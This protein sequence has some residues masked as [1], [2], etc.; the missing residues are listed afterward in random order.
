MNEHNE[1]ERLISM[2]N[3]MIIVYLIIALAAFGALTGYFLISRGRA[4]NAQSENYCGVAAMQSAR[5]VANFCEN[6]EM[7]SCIAFED[8]QLSAF[9][10]KGSEY[11]RDEITLRNR[12]TELLTTASYMSDYCDF[13]I[14]YSNNTTAGIVS[15][16][17]LDHF[18]TAAYERSVELLDG[19]DDSWNVFYSDNVSRIC[20]LKRVNSNAV[21]IS[22]VYST[23]FGHVF[24][25]L[26]DTSS[27]SLYVVDKDN[28][29]IYSAENTGTSYGNT[30]PFEILNKLDGR[31]N[32]TIADEDL[33]CSALEIF[34]GWRLYAVVTPGRS[35]LGNQNSI[36][37][38]VVIIGLSMML[39]FVI[40]GFMIS[41]VY[42]SKRTPRVSEERIDSVTGV[43]T[44]YYCEERISDLIEISLVGGT[45][46][47]AL[48][49]IEDLE[50]IEER[51]GSE[52]AGESR[53][54][55]AEI[56]MGQFGNETAVGMNI[57]RDFVVF[58]DFSDFDIF[59]AHNDLAAG[60]KELRRSL[61]EVYVGENG[62]YRL[63]ITIGACIYPD[64]GKTFDELEYK[65][66]TA[67]KEAVGSEDKMCIYQEK[68]EGR[69][70]GGRK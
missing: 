35:A 10:P 29:I 54:K 43:L 46:A 15:D 14:I 21:F 31:I 57:D 50:L 22:S 62:D 4:L 37:T 36:E 17:T 58:S 6:I 63:D 3:T 1:T 26:I 49:R 69:K 55:V 13:G 39:M 7:A 53:K 47:Y 51:L 2:R 42:S 68:P 28:R 41:S 30:M 52:F 56:I 33:I 19:N 11:T 25:K 32:V 60:F 66:K 12:L 61:N 27:L 38:T 59:K 48:I 34:N 67:L 40:A 20:Y 18:G 9:Y 8:K 23:R 70:G 45:W 64:H 44:P 65:A 16:G 5:N 24:G